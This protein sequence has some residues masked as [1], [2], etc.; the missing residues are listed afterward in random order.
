MIKND[1]LNKD[2]QGNILKMKK[3]NYSDRGLC[4]LFKGKVNTT[5]MNIELYVY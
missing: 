1:F 5:D 2:I 4:V 3:E